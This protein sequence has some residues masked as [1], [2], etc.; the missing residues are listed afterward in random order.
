V[1][2]KFPEI[3]TVGEPEVVL[4]LMISRLGP[5]FVSEPQSVI[6]EESVAHQRR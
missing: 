1:L 6:L 2:W 4:A 5:R 3:V